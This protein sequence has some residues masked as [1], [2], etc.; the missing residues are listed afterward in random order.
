MVDSSVSQ[1]CAMIRIP[2]SIILSYLEASRSK[3][4]DTGIVRASH[5]QGARAMLQS[6]TRF[7]AYRW[8][9]SFDSSHLLPCYNF[10]ELVLHNYGLVLLD[11]ETPCADERAGLEFLELLVSGLEA[12]FDDCRRKEVSGQNFQSPQP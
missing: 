6:K 5:P 11:N 12:H 4:E 2:P 8:R 10:A 9:P 7:A 3:H 1:W